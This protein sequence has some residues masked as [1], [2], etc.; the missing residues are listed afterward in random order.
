MVVLA[1]LMHRGALPSLGWKRTHVPKRVPRD[2]RW[3]LLA[4]SFIFSR[5][6]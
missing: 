2:T 1:F 6:G 3:C 4:Q 5:L